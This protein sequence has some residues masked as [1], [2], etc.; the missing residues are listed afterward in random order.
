M[1]LTKAKIWDDMLSQRIK[2]ADLI[3]TSGATASPNFLGIKDTL[4]QGLEGDQVAK[5]V[6]GLE[7]TEDAWS[8]LYEGVMDGCYPYIKALAEGFYEISTKGKTEK[9]VMKELA[10][11]MTAA[12]ETIA[13]RVITRGTVSTSGISS[14]T[15]GT[16]FRTTTDENNK[17]IESGQMGKIK[18]E[19]I[20]D[21]Q[22]GAQAGLEDVRF[23]GVGDVFKN[24]INRKDI[25]DKIG[26]TKVACAYSNGNL[27][28]DAGFDSFT[29][30]NNG[31]AASG[32]VMNNTSYFTMI[33]KDTSASDR[34]IYRYP[35]GQENVAV[36]AGVAVQFNQDANIAQ[37]I[38]RN[39]FRFSNDV[40]YALVCPVMRRSSCDGTF[41]LTL[42][43]Q[44][45]AYTV[46]SWTNDQ[47]ALATLGVGDRKGWYSVFKDD[48]ENAALTPRRREGVQVKLDLASRTTG[49]L[50]MS[51]P[52][53]L[54]MFEYNG[55]FYLVVAGDANG[56]FLKGD[57][58]TYTDSATEAG[59]N[60]FHLAQKYGVSLPH[61]TS[62]ETYSD[63]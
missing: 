2:I 54:P 32:W 59:R 47:W 12:S 34:K 3:Y 51:H 13:S 55:A 18:I 45:E 27:L 10:I 33:N 25:T 38:G 26:E 35:L 9:Q 62:S 49:A 24:W 56:D 5:E 29:L 43:S 15:T 52:F 21:K 11:A 36:P 8:K 53:L 61:A 41:T 42:G 48:W 7:S 37:Y 17:E 30:A 14:N 58:Y 60:Q 50:V 44:T 20:R 23:S 63:A 6:Q 19:I 1:A 28:N 16:I 31:S 4:I 22:T 40:P 46:S 57:F 39:L